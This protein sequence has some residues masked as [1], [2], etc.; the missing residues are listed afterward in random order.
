MAQIYLEGGWGMY[1]TTLFGVL[2]L[3]AAVKLVMTPNDAWARVFRVLAGITVAA[4][5]LGT[6]TGLIS[7]FKAA[8]KASA[9]DQLTFAVTGSY[10]SLNN[11]T[12]AL[13]LVIL[14]SLLA[15]IAALRR[16]R[17]AS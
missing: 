12:L 13:V 11:L 5:L 6:A 16:T 2:L 9:A 17:T 15:A 14:A 3:V 10:E 7:T 8:A 4:G 1:P